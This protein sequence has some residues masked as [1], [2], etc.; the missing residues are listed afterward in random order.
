M[1]SCAF[2]YFSL[3]SIK[4]ALGN[5]RSSLGP[6]KVHIW[7]HRVVTA[8][9]FRF[10][11]WWFLEDMVPVWWHYCDSMKSMLVGKTQPVYQLKVWL[12]Y[13]LLPGLFLLETW[14]KWHH[15]EL[16][17]SLNLGSSFTMSNVDHLLMY[18]TDTELLSQVE[19]IPKF[20]IGIL[21]WVFITQTLPHINGICI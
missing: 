18:F 4:K 8:E 20:L 16:T 3:I 7:Q 12:L 5:L 14:Q 17:L 15:E 1:R 11:W 2:N 19:F 10:Q 13:K 6:A 9:I 21:N